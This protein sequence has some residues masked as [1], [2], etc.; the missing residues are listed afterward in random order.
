MKTILLC[1]PVPPKKYFFTRLIIGIAFI[2]SFSIKGNAQCGAGYTPVYL[3]WDNLD[4]F[5]ANGYYGTINPATGVAFVTAAMWQTQKFAMGTNFVT[6]ATTIPAF[7]A[8]ALSGDRTTHTGNAGQHTGA[9]IHYDPTAAGSTI[10]ITFDTEVANASFTL[11]D[12][13][14]SAIMTVKAT[15][16][17]G[18]LQTLAHT[19]YGA[20]ILTV[21][22][23]A[24][25]RRFTATNTALGY[26]VNTGAVTISI[27]GPVKQI[28]IK[29]SILGTNDEFFLSD[30]TACVADPSF[31]IDYH[32]SPTQP[33]TG[34][35]AYY[36][37]NP[38]T[39][40]AYMLDPVTAVAQHIFSD[41]GSGGSKMN[42]LA[43]DPIGHYMYYVMDNAPMPGPP[44]N[45][46]LKRYNFN[47]E[48]IETVV[49]DV[50]TLG[51]PC[52]EQGVEFGA[53]AFYN[54]SLYLGIE[55]TD[56][57][58]YATNAESVIWRIDFDGSYN[59]VR[60]VQA[61]ATPGDNGT[62]TVLHD[63]G[64]FVVKDSTIITHATTATSANN[65]YLHVRMQ[66]NTTTTYA[67]N[68]ET[69][70]Q[71]GMIYDKS[72]YRTKSA[73]ALY[74]NAG[75]IG[76]TTNITVTSCSPAW[77]GNAGDASDPFKPKADF[78]DAPASYD[79]VAL[80]PAVNDSACNNTT[81]RIG[82][83]WG[84]E[85]S[86]YTSANA[87]GDDEEDG[88]STVTILNSN[89]VTYNHVQQATFLNNTGSDVTVGAWLDYDVDGVFEAGE[90]RIATLSSN[91]SP[92]VVT[93][94]W[95]SLNIPIGT[96]NTFLRIRIT[97]STMTTSSA[98]G[99]YADGETED[100]PVIS[101]NIPLAINL[102]DFNVLV[103]ADKSVDVR[104]SAISTDEGD[105]FE[106][107][108]S[109]DQVNWVTI[110]T[111]QAGL[112][113]SFV[114]YTLIDTK[115]YS[116]KSYYRLKLIEKNGSSRFSSIRSIYLPLTKNELVISPN[117]VN[118]NTTLM[119]NAVSNG[120][121]TL[122]IRSL[123]GQLLV[124]RSLTLSSGD[125]RIA[126]DVSSF[127]P[128]IYI[129]ELATKDKTIT[130][131]MFVTR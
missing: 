26:T 31:P 91:G 92:Q 121:G 41:P 20:T 40:H 59:V 126:V 64:D 13:D 130:N 111:K 53:A 77:S 16:T 78:G 7:N 2:F 105:E 75:G 22:G 117:P 14:R 29:D 73:V 101:T 38:Q 131:K 51:I 24:T 125:N 85:W 28:V 129:V 21:A 61:F 11:N 72:V 113:G 35:P 48:Q 108:R 43:Y 122:R 86:K 46:I 60:A 9:D 70:G 6:F 119:V 49:A 17:A 58:V 120:T 84:R 102:I 1:P 80:S 30:I 25:W 128:G 100:Y 127:N 74:D 45:F 34:Q 82:A 118:N 93:F 8:S 44:A 103:N 63:W 32:Y 36:L 5:H 10:T 88:I 94:T 27:T 55:G 81:L 65:Q 56:G 47:T 104:W 68:A 96:A 42:S 107:Q 67:G 89:G 15:N 50:R 62:G 18:G 23:T 95:S 52:F 87:D 114:A 99:W 19:T 98:T 106:I 4:Y 37:V 66:S 83:A 79:P 109:A 57:V 123:S 90:G 33:W 12:I 110:G 97:S 69:A 71:L 3:N 115:P 54:G 39:L 116:G 124:A 76:A 112:T